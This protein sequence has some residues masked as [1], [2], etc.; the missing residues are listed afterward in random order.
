MPNG[1]RPLPTANPET[2]AYWD[3]LRAGELRLERCVDCTHISFP[4]RG[5]CPACGSRVT[6][7]HVASGL[8][9]LHSYVISHR[10]APGFEVPYV[11]AV[12]ELAEGPRMMTNLL[13]V[14]PD[15]DCLP[16]DMPLELV[17]TAF[18]DEVTLPLFRPVDPEVSGGTAAGSAA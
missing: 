10:P 1:D 13:D 6:G 4:P 14:E 3:G 2:A 12:V 15:P 11:I 16:L 8:A 17:P 5:F 9:T 18:S 7:T